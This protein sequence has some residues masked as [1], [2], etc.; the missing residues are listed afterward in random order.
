MTSMAHQGDAQILE[1]TGNSG[2]FFTEHRQVAWVLLL[3]TVLWGVYGYR[4]MRQRKDPDIPVRVAVAVC[5]WPGGTAV[6]VEE[7]VTRPIEQKIAENTHIHPASASEYGIKSLTLP[8]LSI[9]YVQLDENVADTKKEFADINLKLNALSNGLPQGAGPINFQ[10]DFG[11]TAAL[12]LTVASPAADRMEVAVRAQTI[13]HTIEQ[14]RRGA[15]D[16]RVSIVAAFP[17]SVPLDAVRPHV[18]LFVDLAAQQG[19]LRDIRSFDGPGFVGVD[20][21]STASDPAIQ[22]FVKSFI[23]DQL[24]E[25][26]LHPD[27]WPPVIIRKP[28]DTETRL[29]AG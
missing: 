10:S 15:Q 16:A 5:P 18:R 27:G 1:Q 20:G 25:S 14:V 23:A 28:Q 22:A 19:L 24:H 6:D 11:D 29:A 4:S 12:M 2:R 8:G 21:M 7:L 3:G 17:Q 26:E 9:V 13:R